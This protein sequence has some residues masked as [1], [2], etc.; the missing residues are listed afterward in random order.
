MANQP[1]AADG[2]HRTSAVVRT[3][4]SGRVEEVGNSS[5]PQGAHAGSDPAAVLQLANRKLLTVQ[6]VVLNVAR[7]QSLERKK[8]CY[9]ALYCHSVV[10][11]QRLYF[12]SFN[13]YIL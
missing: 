9:I 10:T 5:D 13:L 7:G 11:T 2:R 8:R 4:Q 1:W 3:D 6:Q 12:I